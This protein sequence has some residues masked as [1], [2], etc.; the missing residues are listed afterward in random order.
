MNMNG[1]YMNIKNNKF[2]SQ[3]GFSLI[4]LMVAMVI[5]LIVLLGLVSLFNNSSILNKAQSGLASLQENGRYAISRIKED[6][7]QAGRKH[8]ATLAMPN[9]LFSNWNQGYE[10]ST[11]SVDANVNLNANT[12]TNGFPAINQIQLDLTADAD[13]LP[14]SVVTAGLQEY[15][16]DPQYFIRGHECGASNCQPGV[17]I[18][19]ADT[20]GVIPSIGTNV[21]DRAAN[22]DV[23]TVR[24]LTG[25]NRVTNI[26]K[27]GSGNTI[28]LEDSEPISTNLA[29][30]ANCNFSLIGNASWNINTLNFNVNQ[31]FDPDLRPDTRAFNMAR[32]FK[33]VT[34][35]VG[36]DNDPNR[37]GRQFSS[38]YRAE[39][40]VAQ[41]LVEGVERFDVY[42]LAQTQTGH[43]V[44]LTA[45]QVQSVSGG[46]DLNSDDA[47]DT[48]IGC[49]NPPVIAEPTQINNVQLANGQGCLWRSI[50]A[51]EIHVLMNTVN[52]SSMIQDEVFI[53][54]PDGTTV[55]TPSA[56]LPS[57]LDRERMYRREFTA[58]I[59]I[60]SYTL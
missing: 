55:Q 58:T 26:V 52:D 28:T 18:I 32:D 2:Q 10:M 59:P 38:L 51:M 6:V 8:C 25:G 3:H 5:G 57:G 19:G 44:R 36:I 47:M 21:G 45:N 41:Q 23:L 14:D 7:E 31:P 1:N 39:N 29:M 17:N 49:I 53:Y 33:T 56:T 30:V 27:T 16:L 43:V 40:G 9:R 12:S 35:F 22:T 60:R 11:W 48:M 34:Y 4:E 13:Q 50:Y 37:A 15:P 46:G 24:Y 54:S 42:Y 20:S